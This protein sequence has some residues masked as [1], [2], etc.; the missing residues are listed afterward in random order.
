MSSLPDNKSVSF[1]DLLLPWSSFPFQNISQRSVEVQVDLT[2]SEFSDT[3]P[4]AAI[5]SDEY[6]IRRK[7]QRQCQHISGCQRYAQGNTKLCISHGGG[8]RCQTIGCT[9]SVQGARSSHCIAHGGGRRCEVIGCARS[10]RG[11]SNRCVHHG[12]GARCQVVGCKKSAQRP[13]DY[14]I[15][16]GG[17]KK[18]SVAGCEGLARSQYPHLCINHARTMDTDYNETH[19]RDSLPAPLQNIF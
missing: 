1:S 7:R 12:G 14:C 19:K 17:G 3:L 9:K 13:S 4:T 2:L 15:V 6:L 11:N 16:H 10:S 18:C 8:R 5:D